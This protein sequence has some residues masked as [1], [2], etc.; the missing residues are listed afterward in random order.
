MSYDI[1]SY[2]SRVADE[3]GQRGPQNYVAGDD[4][5]FY[6]YKRAKFLDRFLA[7]LDVAGG[8]VL[9]LG[10]GPGGN[11]VELSRRG[12]ATL[13]GIDISAGMLALATKALEGSPVPVELKKTDGLRLPLGDH[14]VDL[15]FTV[16]VLQHNVDPAGLS[17]VVGELCRVTAERIVIM[18]DT[19]KSLTVPDGTPG[20]AR[21]IEVYRAEFARRG[22]RLESTR[23]LNLR[24]SRRMHEA[25]RRHLLPSTHKEGEPLGRTVKA[26][27]RLSLA[28]TR[29]LDDRTPDTGDLTQMVFVRA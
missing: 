29:P 7:A 17:S 5:P 28:I 20:I 13:I 16:T 2:W 12:P 3:I 10:C 9:E 22:F 15:A 24:Y 1:E 4:D 23:Y 21:P 11:L 18:E 25:I 8:R 19:G 27:L 6:R 14:S 26:A